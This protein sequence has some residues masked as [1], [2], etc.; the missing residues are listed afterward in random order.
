M[1]KQISIA[2][3]LASGLALVVWL[4]LSASAAWGQAGSRTLWLPIAHKPI[5]QSNNPVHSGI[6]TYYNATGEG[7]C[8]FDASPKDLMVTALNAE[9]Y[10]HAA[11]CGAH[12]AVE[13]TGRVGDRPDCRPVPRV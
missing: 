6:A 3:I 10:D 1:P 2:K 9:Q 7:A 4:A 13:W 12:V 11:W 5:T 8:L